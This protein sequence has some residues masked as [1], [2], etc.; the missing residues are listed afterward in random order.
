MTGN[1]AEAEEAN[2]HY[3][4]ALELAGDNPRFRAMIL[5]ELGLLHTD[6]GN[7]RIA[8]GYLLDRDKLPYTDNSEGLDVLL[9]KAQAI[10]HEGRA[11]DASAAGEAALA[12]VARNPSLAKYGPLALDWAAVDNLAAGHF[13][14][15]LA[16]YDE[17][18][19]I[20]DASTAPTAARNRLVAR[21]SRAAAE[22]GAKAAARALVDLDYVERSLLDPTTAATLTWPHASAEDVAR[23]YQLIA[24]GLR[25]SANRELHR[26]NEEARALEARRSILAQ[27]L[28]ASNRPEVAR[29]EMLADA[30]LA[31]NAGQR[32]DVAAARKWLGEAVARADELRGQA[33]G[34]SDKGGFDVLRLASVLTLSMHAPLVP[35]LPKR[36]QAA[37]AELAARREPSLRP[38]E[39]WLEVYGALL[40]PPAP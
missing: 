11:A 40:A 9:S 20:L 35:G 1:L 28:R 23:T 21:I 26:W 16:L 32:E 14:R 22:V 4:V 3:L 13:A 37:S 10:L 17:A 29:E 2:V 7:Y 6:V 38:F 25:A 34:R 31:W 5:G 8:L 12:M 36:I 15:A 30:Q 19:P 24:S 33:N 18:V 27:Q 39:G